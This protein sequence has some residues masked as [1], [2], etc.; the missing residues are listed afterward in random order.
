LEQLETANLFITAL[1]DE[2]CWYRYH[3]LFAELLHQQLNRTQSTL[4]PIFHRRASVWYEENE[5]LLEAV[6]HALAAEDIERMVHLVE[7]NV[8]TMVGRGELSIIMGWLDAL[9]GE[10]VRSPP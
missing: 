9:P 8:L 3:H 6:R 1:D 2:R 7:R 10:V 4:V 5:L